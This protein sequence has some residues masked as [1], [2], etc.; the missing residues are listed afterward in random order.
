MCDSDVI[1]M[2]SEWLFHPDVGARILSCTGQT[3]G[4]GGLYHRLMSQRRTVEGL[5]DIRDLAADLTRELERAGVDMTKAAYLI[6]V[7]IHHEATERWRASNARRRR[8]NVV[9]HSTARHRS[10][11]GC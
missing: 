2:Y 8:R 7:R 4:P 6:A 3:R 10:Q 1:T 5:R 9:E 11:G